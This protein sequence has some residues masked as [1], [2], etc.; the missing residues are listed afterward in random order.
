MVKAAVAVRP[1]ANANS[2]SCVRPSAWCVDA[3]VRWLA[4]A[5]ATRG[6]TRVLAEET[7]SRIRDERRPRR[8]RPLDCQCRLKTD[9][10]TTRSVQK[11]KKQNS[12]ADCRDR[13]GFSS[14]MNSNFAER[15]SALHTPRAAMS[16]A[17]SPSSAAAAAA[18]ADAVT[19]SLRFSS[20]ERAFSKSLDRAFPSSAAQFQVAL[21]AADSGAA[22]AAASSP[23]SSSSS[24]S[25][26][27]NISGMSAKELLYALASTSSSASSSSSSTSSKSSDAPPVSVDKAAIHRLADLYVQMTMHLRTACRVCL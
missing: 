16:N 23:A 27:R 19:S 17:S 12:G 4:T 3:M 2:S 25:G 14:S 22:S 5:H 8:T 6:T 18:V 13:A 21:A 1:N 9:T 24:S 11:S 10:P 26:Q 7:A 20:L 15:P